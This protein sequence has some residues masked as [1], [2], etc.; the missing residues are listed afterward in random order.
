MKKKM[1]VAFLYSRLLCF[2]S[3]RSGRK[4]ISIFSA[5]LNKPP[6]AEL[7]V[8]CGLEWPKGNS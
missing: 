4:H 5:A 7:M 1:G 8:I 3:R 6:K 2:F